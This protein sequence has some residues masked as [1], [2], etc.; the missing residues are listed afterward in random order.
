VQHREIKSIEIE[1]EERL[2]HL[3]LDRNFMRRFS[4][5]HEI[6]AILLQWTLHLQMTHET[7]FVKKPG[8]TGAQA[9]MTQFSGTG[10]GS[11]SL[12]SFLS[13]LS[14]FLFMGERPITESCPGAT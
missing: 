9:I 7:I 13:L 14:F 2:D 4:E 10:R 8:T 1:F 3:P 11:E 6:S 5:K 12:V